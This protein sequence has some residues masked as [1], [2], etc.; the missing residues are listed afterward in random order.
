MRHAQLKLDLR[1]DAPA[2]AR[3]ADPLPV[4]FAAGGMALFHRER[5]LALGGF[6]DIFLPGYHEDVDLCWRAWSR[7]W[8]SYYEPR[9]VVHHDHGQG[10]FTLNYK[11]L[12][13]RTLM[14]RN[15]VLLN[16]INL[17]R[18]V[19]AQLGWLALHTA[20]R[21]LRRLLRPSKFVTHLMALPLIL[22]RLPEALRRRRRERAER[23]LANR[24]LFAAIHTPWRPLLSNGSGPASEQTAP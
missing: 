11:H 20:S 10:A 7:G 17:E 1:W 6:A 8:G 18:S 9:S 4:M 16:L 24:E 15:W 21:V 23:V 5:F 13:L 12:R 22:A 14:R 19:L 3:S 2:E